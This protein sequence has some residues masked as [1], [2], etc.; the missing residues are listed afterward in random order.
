M[1]RLQEESYFIL[2]QAFLQGTITTGTMRIQLIPCLKQTRAEGGGYLSITVCGS[3]NILAYGLHRMSVEI[4]D[5]SEVAGIAHIH[6]I[7]YG[8][9]ACH[10]RILTRLQILI[11]DIIGI[12]GRDEPMHRQPHAL[13]NKSRAD[14]SEVATGHTGHG[15]ALPPSTLQLGTG[16]EI[17]KALRQET[18][19]IDAVGTGK[20]HVSREFGIHECALHKGL[21]VIKHAIHLQGC[22]VLAQ[23]GKLTF[24]YGAH[25]TL[26]IQYIYMYAGHAQESVCYCRTCI[27]RRGHK[28]ID[29]FVTA[30]ATDEMPQQTRHEACPYI[31]ESQGWAM[32]KFKRINTRSHLHQRYIET[33]SVTYEGMQ[34]L[35]RHIF[36][37]ETVGHLASY[38][39]KGIV[40]QMSKEI[41]GKRNDALWHV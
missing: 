34:L 28:Y 37:K 1:C 23:C 18:C 17:I 14:V 15:L 25:L 31:L 21:T 9:Q 12:V 10:R 22:D 27:T 29:Q 5:T 11:E 13:T 35:L 38:F 6:S 24:L 16:I 19:H 4:Q 36:S 8:L 40:R 30:T 7:G 41:T 32:E 3:G 20:T 39:L 26:G 2:A 33:E